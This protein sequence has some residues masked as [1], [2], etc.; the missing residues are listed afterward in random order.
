MNNNILEALND[1]KSMQKKQFNSIFGILK[2][3]SNQQ[4]EMINLLKEQIEI[5]KELLEV[6]R[7]KKSDKKIY[8]TDDS[9]IELLHKQDEILKRYKY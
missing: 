3:Q 9:A 2:I 4:D 8:N 6:F 5:Q 7:Y 1:I